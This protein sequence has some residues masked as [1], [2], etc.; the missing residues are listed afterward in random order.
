MALNELIKACLA[1]EQSSLGALQL[2]RPEATRLD[3]E[4]L[5]VEGY[6]PYRSVSFFYVSYA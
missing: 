1:Q 4:H 6:G 3:F 5:E 2:M